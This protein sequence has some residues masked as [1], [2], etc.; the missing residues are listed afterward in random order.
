LAHQVPPSGGNR[1]I[2]HV[3][4]RESLAE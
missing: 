3:R 4:L 1:V 2:G